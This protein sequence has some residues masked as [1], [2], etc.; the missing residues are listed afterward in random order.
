MWIVRELSGET[1]GRVSET[2]QHRGTIASLWHQPLDSRSCSPKTFSS[3]TMN[4]CNGK[5]GVREFNFQ[6]NWLHSAQLNAKKMVCRMYLCG[7]LHLFGVSSSRRKAERWWQQEQEKQA[8]VQKRCSC[9]KEGD[10]ENWTEWMK[11]ETIRGGRVSTLA[12]L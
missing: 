8:E 3:S 9:V 4:C 10:G 6:H 5:G 7:K 1:R 12:V 11:V 2:L